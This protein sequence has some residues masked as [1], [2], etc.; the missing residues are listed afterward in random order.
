[1]RL[2]IESWNGVI[3][4]LDHDHM[5]IL[6]VTEYERALAFT[7][8]TRALAL[9]ARVRPLSS[10]ATAEVGT[11]EEHSSTEQCRPVAHTSDNIVAVLSVSGAR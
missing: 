3:L 4:E 8:L 1:M 7:G 2:K 10:Y 6:P 9:L 5:A 11:D